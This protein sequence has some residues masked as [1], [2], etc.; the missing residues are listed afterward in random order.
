MIGNGDVF[1][2]MDWNERMS[3]SG[4]DTCMLARGALIKVRGNGMD[5]TTG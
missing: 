2:F 1:S 4:V 5:I 3:E